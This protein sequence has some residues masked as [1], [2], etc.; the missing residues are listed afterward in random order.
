VVDT[1]ILV[2]AFSTKK[3]LSS[4]ASELMWRILNGPYRIAVD[5]EA[6]I[7]EVEYKKHMRNNQTMT[8][9]W[10]RMKLKDKIALRCGRG[11]QFGDLKEMDNCFACVAMRTPDRV[12]ITE[13]KRH[14]DAD[15]KKKLLQRNVHVLDLESAYDRFC[16]R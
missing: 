14:F 7:V 5:D 4:K 15:V 9:W 6:Q 11:V 13:N 8:T 3:D 1:N 2:L 16:S 10:T 12:L